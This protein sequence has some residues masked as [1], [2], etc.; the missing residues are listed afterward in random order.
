MLGLDETRIDTRSMHPDD[1]ALRRALSVSSALSSESHASGSVRTAIHGPSL[2]LLVCCRI[3]EEYIWVEGVVPVPSLLLM[4]DA[5]GTWVALT[6]GVVDGRKDTKAVE[7]SKGRHPQ[8]NL[9]R[10]ARIR[11][12]ARRYVTAIISW[13]VQR[14][15]GGQERG[16]TAAVIAWCGGRSA[17]PSF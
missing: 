1:T 4:L 8:H 2:R 13:R 7:E 15:G 5:A 14:K 16:G 12:S 10:E 17:G 3:A 11:N 6:M 9:S